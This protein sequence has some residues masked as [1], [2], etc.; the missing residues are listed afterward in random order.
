MRYIQLLPYVA[1]VV[2]LTTFSQITT[3]KVAAKPVANRVLIYD[4]TENFLTHDVYRYIGQELY[5]LGQ[6]KSSQKYGYR[7]FYTD[8]VKSAS[9]YN[10]PIY[11][12]INAIGSDYNALAGK[13]FTVVDTVNHDKSSIWHT[14]WF[15]KLK[16]KETGDIV[17]FEYDSE[18]EFLFPFIVV[19]F[20]EKQ[21][22]ELV[23]KSYYIDDN[24]LS[25]SADINTGLPITQRTGQKWKCVDFTIEEN[26]YM[27][28]LVIE[29]SLNERTTVP[30]RF[31]AGKD[32]TGIS[33]TEHEG[34]IYKKKYG[35]EAFNK[36]LKNII[37]V[38]MT[39]EL[40][41][42]AWGEPRSKNETVFEGGKREQW[43]YSD[44]YLYFKNGVLSAIQDK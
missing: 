36:V 13:Y 27:P 9:T 42:L 31:V 2:P 34:E 22:K 3:T 12:A 20:F 28:S 17:Y 37:W 26:Y 8:V 39:K 4:S 41:I 40:C 6:H 25:Q 7:G 10:Y 11:K 33:F 32:R 29:N 35:T 21:K 38:G 16:E 5:V 1:W 15:L 19:G 18:S 43:V 44:S 30:Y 14:K 24:I 23:G